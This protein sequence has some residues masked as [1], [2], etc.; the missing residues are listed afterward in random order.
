MI[1]AALHVLGMSNIDG[2][3]DEKVISSPD[4]LWTR[5]NQERK[6][7]LMKISKMV[8]SYFS[9]NDHQKSTGDLIHDY[10]KNFLSI[11]CFYLIT[12]MP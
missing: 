2:V 5:S 9:F 6:E 8:V 10:T 3:P 1:Q 11:G 4:T 12:K 7:T